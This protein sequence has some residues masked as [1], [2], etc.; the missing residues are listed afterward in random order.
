MTLKFKVGDKV[1]VTDNKSASGYGDYFPERFVGEIVQ[2]SLVCDGGYEF[3]D[4]KNLPW[5]IYY[6]HVRLI[7]PLDKL[8]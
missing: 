5:F 2:I 1:I 8:L 6:D 4:D 7:T 3:L